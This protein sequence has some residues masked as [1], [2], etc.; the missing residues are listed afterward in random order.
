MR[1]MVAGLFWS[2]LETGILIAFTLAGGFVNATVDLDRTYS[3]IGLLTVFG[4][5][6]L[7]GYA[8]RDL[9]V[10]LK[11][12]FIAQGIS[13]SVY[14]LTFSVIIPSGLNSFGEWGSMYLIG[15][16]ILLFIV[17]GLVSA[18]GSAFAEKY[19]RPPV[20]PL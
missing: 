5:A 18:V 16:G 10:L 11:S 8:V 4:L 14:L 19:S 2:L 17:S 20:R 3:I 6:F 1:A 15:L 13:L 7:M 12:C 9:S